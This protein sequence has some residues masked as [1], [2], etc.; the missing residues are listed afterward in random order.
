M[1]TSN[2][3]L[4]SLVNCFGNDYTLKNVQSFCILPYCGV[5]PCILVLLYLHCHT[6]SR[7]NKHRLT[8]TYSTP[9][10][11]HKC[12]HA[13]SCMSVL[14]LH[15]FLLH[16]VYY[17]FCNCLN[18]HLNR[19]LL[20][21]EY[22]A[23]FDSWVQQDFPHYR[24][25]STVFHFCKMFYSLYSSHI[26]LGICRIFHRTLIRTKDKFFLWVIS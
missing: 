5:M 13:M 11:I 15:V 12:D 7:A 10:D 20:G 9:F 23:A 19:F 2:C 24:N 17:S 4:V 8:T 21:M 22:S 3:F 14:Q 1:L 18:H 26:L 16:I 25:D 6:H